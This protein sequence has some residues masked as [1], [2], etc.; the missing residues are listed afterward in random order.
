MEK[1]WVRMPVD[2]IGKISYGSLVM[3]SILLNRDNGSHRVS[4]NVSQLAKM[5]GCSRRHAETLLKELEAAGLILDR[6]REQFAA[7]FTLRADILPPKK[8]SGAKPAMQSAAPDAAHTAEPGASFDL[9]D[10]DRLV[11][12]F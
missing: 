8:H 6:K 11:N 3:L 4:I 10:F 7:A 2:L 9:S 1:L 5:A 12:R